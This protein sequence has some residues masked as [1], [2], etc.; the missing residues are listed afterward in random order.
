MFLTVRSVHLLISFGESTV[1]SSSGLFKDV[2]NALLASLSP[3][4]AVVLASSRMSRRVVT[5]CS[6]GGLTDFLGG[7]SSLIIGGLV[8]SPPVLVVLRFAGWIWGGCADG[9]GCVR[10][11]SF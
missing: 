9:C 8:V 6:F 5:S 11:V 10:F 7:M 1:S 4:G 2:V 3:S